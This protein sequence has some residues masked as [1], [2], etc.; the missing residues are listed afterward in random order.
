MVVTLALMGIVP[1]T[2]DPD[3]GDVIVTTRLPLTCAE[4]GC[5]ERER[6]TR[7]TNSAAA[8]RDVTRDA[9]I[10]LIVFYL[11]LAGSTAGSMTAEAASA[12]K[13][14]RTRKMTPALVLESGPGAHGETAPATA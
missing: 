6:R 9:W 4:A 14:G 1:P 13:T 7:V 12:N 10:L 5:V 3:V 2:V 11:L 8:Q